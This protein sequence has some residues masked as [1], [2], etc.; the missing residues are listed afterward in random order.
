MNS[1]IKSETQCRP[2]NRKTI[3]LLVIVASAALAVVTIIYYYIGT[4]QPTAN[5]QGRLFWNGQP[6]EEGAVKLVGGREYPSITD[7]DGE[8]NF[9][10]PLGEYFF[11]Y[12]ASEDSDWT[13]YPF[14]LYPESYLAPPEFRLPLNIK[15]D[16]DLGLLHTIK[17][18]FL[19]IVCPKPNEKLQPQPTFS[20]Q[21]FPFAKDYEVYIYKCDESCT[22]ILDHDVI[23][24]LTPVDF[25]RTEEITY[26]P[27]SLLTS[28][29]YLLRIEARGFTSEGETV[30]LASG[31]VVFEIP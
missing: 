1:G 2:L 7:E 8:F 5:V 27:N 28:G 12:K 11:Y 13:C 19:G 15:E 4:L 9:T 30:A 6:L 29:S 21:E 25:E 23:I 20:W 16:L 14:V 24:G 3:V 26:K 31:N 18:N 17:K 22:Y 10:V